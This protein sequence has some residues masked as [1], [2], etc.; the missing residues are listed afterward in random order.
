MPED[1]DLIPY[2]DDEIDVPVEMDG[3]DCSGFVASIK[4]LTASDGQ[5]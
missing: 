5:I 4:D 3:L 1:P 2:G